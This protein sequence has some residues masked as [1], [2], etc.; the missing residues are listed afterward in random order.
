MTSALIFLLE[1]LLLFRFSRRAT[2]I[3]L[4]LSKRLGVLIL[5]PG[6]FIHELSHLLMAGVLGVRVGDFSLRPEEF[7]RGM[8]LGS[9]SIERVDPFRRF[10]IGTAPMVFGLTTLF[11]LLYFASHNENFQSWQMLVL[12]TYLTFAIANTLFS[13]PSDLKGSKILILILVSILIVLKVL[14][15]TVNISLSPDS[16]KRVHDTLK[17]LSLYLLFPIA[18]DGLILFFFRTKD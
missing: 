9:V 18:M 5:L 8:R 12:V 1:F 16:V 4:R 17:M 7:D 6:T 11:T 15:V 14:G 3:I 10:L 2:G 13:S